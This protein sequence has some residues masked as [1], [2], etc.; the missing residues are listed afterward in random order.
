MSKSSNFEDLN[1]PVSSLYLLAAPSTPEEVRTEVLDRAAKGEKVTHKEVKEA[2]GRA[3]SAKVSNTKSAATVQ[4]PAEQT[5]RKDVRDEAPPSLVPPSLRRASES[6]RQLSLSV[7][8]P[9]LC[10]A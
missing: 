3:R 5:E 9:V 6:S 1:L 8:A 7:S 10:S 4:P 2:I